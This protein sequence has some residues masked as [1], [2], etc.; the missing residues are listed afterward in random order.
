MSPPSRSQF[1]I[2]LG[3]AI[4]LFIFHFPNYD[5]FDGNISFTTKYLQLTKYVADRTGII[6]M[7]QLPLLY[8]LASRN[9]IIMW[10]TGWNFDTMNMYH[11]WVARS[12]VLDAFLHSVLFTVNYRKRGDFFGHWKSYFMKWGV[13]AFI[14]SCF[15]LFFSLRF[16]RVSYYEFFLFSHWIFVCFFTA[17]TWKHLFG[18]GWTVWMYPCVAL[19]AFDRACR[20]GRIAFSS[21]TSTANLELSKNKE[22]VKVKIDY[23]FTWGPN[24]GNY[25]FLYFLLPFLKFWEN[26]PFSCYQSPL[27]GEEQKLCF[28]M[29]TQNGKTKQIANYLAGKEAGRARVPVLIEGPYGHT[30]PVDKSDTIVLIAGGIGITATYSYAAKLKKQAC[31]KHVVL[32]WVTRTHGNIEVMKDEINYLTSCSDSIDV[33][34]YVTNEEAN[35]SPF[36]E[37]TK[38]D[39]SCSDEKK[40]DDGNASGNELGASISYGTPDLNGIISGYVSQAPGTIGF[41]VCGPPAVNDVVRSAVTANMDKGKDRVDLFVEAYNW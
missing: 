20:L 37:K 13:V 27:P 26:H 31:K 41:F 9:S 18:R 17:G 34:I 2:L 24:A 35:M 7:A 1:V 10:C 12:M 22:F 3:Y 6:A 32:L 39:D 15:I 16:F 21:V 28:V 33:S 29:K 4:M 38:S 40:S 8:I 11:R 30:F 36:T 14:C 25:A 5:L 23:S 19:W